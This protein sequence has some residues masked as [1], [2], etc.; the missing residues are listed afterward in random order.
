MGVQKAKLDEET[1]RYIWL[2]AYLC[3]AEKLT[4]SKVGDILKINRL[5]VGRYLKKAEELGVFQ[6]ILRPPPLEEELAAK[7][8]G[9]YHLR[10]V[11]I[12]PVS[13]SHDG[14]AVRRIIGCAAAGYLENLLS[15][16]FTNEP[17]SISLGLAGGRT[18]H[19]MVNAL[20]PKMFSGLKIY[21][22]V[23]GPNPGTAIS[24]SAIVGYMSSIYELEV[25]DHGLVRF[26]PKTK[27][28]KE[29]ILK[30]EKV[31]ETLKAAKRVDVAVVGIGN[32]SKESTLGRTVCD[33]GYEIGNLEK[34]G[35]FAD[36]CS[37]LLDEEGNIVAL[38]YHDSMIGVSASDLRTLHKEFG[39]RVIGVS[40]G[41][42]KAPAIK[43]VLKGGKKG[44]YIDTLITDQMT[45][46]YLLEN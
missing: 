19:R 33:F 45:A 28:E 23:A 26:A 29:N 10:D 2:C 5:K 7:L 16:L 42:G 39:K 4:Q 46:K 14:K 30:L 25:E 9:K 11:R 21:P 43:A 22:L 18:L 6:V 17:R 36:I 31:S 35:V 38:P 37:Q 3:H 13:E 12:V 27:D 41:K 44:P 8:I 34:K 1:R 24:A 32:L 20:Y 15:E 40:G